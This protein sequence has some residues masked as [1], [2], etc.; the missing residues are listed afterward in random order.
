MKFGKD[1]RSHL[2]ETLPAW[3][4]KYLAYKSLKKLIKNLPPDGDPPPVAAAAEVPAGDGD[5][6][7]GIAL[8][9]WFARVLDMELQKLNDFYIEREEWYV[10][11][12]QVLKERIERVKAKKNGA[13]T[14]KSEFTEE[15]LEIRKAFVIIH[16]EMILLQTYS[17]LNFAGLVKILKKYDKRTGGLLS[18]P[19]TQ[20]AR[21]QPF[22]T[23]EPLTRLVRECEAN[24][25]LLF[26]IE[27]EVLE[28]A[29]SS[30][31]LQPQND[32]AASHDPASSV[33]VETSDVYR[34][35]LAAMKAIQGLRKASSTYNPLSLARFFH[36]EDG[37]ACSGAITSESDSYSDSQIEDAEDDD[38]EVQSR[39]QNTAQNAAE[40]QPRDE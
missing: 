21:H 33:D 4:D 18:L 28:S 14:S 35:T 19:F 24:L 12:L 16:G 13:F 8:G 23:T 22:F 34:S 7:G 15:M 26:P 1:F 29:S 30:A 37:E 5:G 11:R 20:R 31:K 38:K 10:I 32:D 17:S 39:E 3:R 36:G 27:A 9:N 2:E 6:D 25:E 40:G